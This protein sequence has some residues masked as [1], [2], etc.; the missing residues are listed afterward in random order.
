[1]STWVACAVAW[2][3]VDVCGPCSL[4]G[5]HVTPWS[6]CSQ[7]PCW[8]CGPCCHPRSC[9]CLWFLPLPQPMSM[10]MGHAATRAILMWVSCT[11]TWGHVKGIY[12][13]C[14]LCSYSVPWP[15]TF[16][17]PWSVLPLTVKSQEVTFVVISMTTDAQIR[18]RD[19]DSLE[20]EPL[21][22]TLIKCD[23][24]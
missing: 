15:E 16:G 1:M 12:W 4:W 14:G 21:K 5:P 9:G 24:V 10:S 8:V 18:G 3:H 22:R 23:E 19:T 17:H 20:R 13:V 7:G 11:A 2:S 6:W